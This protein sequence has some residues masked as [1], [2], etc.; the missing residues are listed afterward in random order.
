[1]AESAFE[2]HRYFFRGAALTGPTAGTHL[3]HRLQTGTTWPAL[4][5]E[6]HELQTVEYVNICSS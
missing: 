5:A 2:K 6:A 4:K 1:M 3:N